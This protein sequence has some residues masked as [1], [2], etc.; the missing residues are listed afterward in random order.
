MWSHAE[1]YLWVF[2]GGGL[3]SMCRYAIAHLTNHL[4]FTFP[5]ATFLA[6]GL[7]CVILGILVGLSMKGNVDNTFKFLIMIGFCGGFSTFST[8]SNETFQLFQMGHFF[9]AFA[10]ILISV[11][12]CLICIYLGIKIVS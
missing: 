5:L 2:I 8:F 7:S 11:L 4:N 6:N 1:N 12:V 3:G 9:H 10:N